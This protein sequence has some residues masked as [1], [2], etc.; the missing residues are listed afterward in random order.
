MQRFLFLA[1]AL[2][3]APV[4]AAASDFLLAPVSQ[5]VEDGSAVVLLGSLSC[6]EASGKVVVKR[7]ES[8]ADGVV[9]VLQS[10]GKAAD[11]SIKIS[12]VAADGLELAAGSAVSIVS[13]S[14]GF[15]LSSEGEV[16]TFIPNELGKSLFYPA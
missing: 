7:V 11:V 16:I 13:I 8:V 9:I 2:C 15:L 10:A 4:W 6:L 3:S 12:G 5:A 1:F 14:T